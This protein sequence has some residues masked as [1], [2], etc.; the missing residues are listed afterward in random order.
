MKNPPRPYRRGTPAK[1]EIRLLQL[2]V[3]MSEHIPLRN[4]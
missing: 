3:D 2:L 4:S 1:I